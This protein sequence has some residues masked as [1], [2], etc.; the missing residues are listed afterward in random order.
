[1]TRERDFQSHDIIQGGTTMKKLLTLA[2]A[3]AVL[4]TFS[5][6]ATAAT[7][8]RSGKSNS[9]E[10]VAADKASPK[11]MTGKVT[12]VNPT[13]KT[14]TVQTTNGLVTFNAA[15]LPALPKVGEMVDIT[16]TPTPAGPMNATTVRSSKS[17]SNL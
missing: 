17:N 7:S 16:A 15:T 5:G 9:S 6:L 3:L 13:A 14:F 10:R 11:L 1:M 4:A 2:L 8:V 12:Q